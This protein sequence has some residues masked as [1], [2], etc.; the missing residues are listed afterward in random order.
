[1]KE[2]RTLTASEIDVRVQSLKKDGTSACFLL[3]KDARCDMAILDE[4]FGSMNWQREHFIRENIIN[5]QRAMVNYCRVSIWDAD[6]GNWVMKEDVGTESNTENAKGE[7][8]DSFKRACVN[9]GIGRELYSAPNIWVNFAEGEVYTD[10]RGNKQTYLKLS[11]KEITY[12]TNRNIASLVL[13]DSKGIERY[14]WY[15]TPKAGKSAL[16]GQK[17]GTTTQPT[18]TTASAPSVVSLDDKLSQDL[19]KAIGT[20]TTALDINGVMN[21]V[22]AGSDD[23]KRAFNKRVKELKLVWDQVNQEYIE[24]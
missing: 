20:F 15:A 5:G 22:K 7:S 9:W 10:N 14:K 16:T 3:Y 21:Q 17:N 23:V 2:I 8:S 11:V 1:M 13:I 19:I 4:T 24:I 18:T 6:K 12:D